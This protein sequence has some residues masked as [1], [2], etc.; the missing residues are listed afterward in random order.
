MIDKYTSGV[1]KNVVR[2]RDVSKIARAE[3]AGI[4]RQTAAPVIVRLVKDPALRVEQAYEETV[5]EAYDVRDIATRTDALV[6]RLRAVTHGS[7][8]SGEVRAQLRAL[9]KEIERLL[10]AQ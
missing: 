10:G 3:R 5:R 9:R 6:E 7:L 2:Y 8:L 1:V 4:D